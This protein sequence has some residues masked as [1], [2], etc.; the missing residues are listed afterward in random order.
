MILI[1]GGSTDPSFFL[2]LRHVLLYGLFHQFM[3]LDHL[4]DEEAQD[5]TAIS[6][7]Y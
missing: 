1:S 3:D 7:R 4:Q 2:R 5:V 6:P